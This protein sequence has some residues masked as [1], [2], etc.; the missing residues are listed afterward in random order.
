MRPV[1]TAACA[2][3]N[4]DFVAAPGVAWPSSRA[5]VWVQVPGPPLLSE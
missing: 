3:W 4:A 2:H 1:R 5:N